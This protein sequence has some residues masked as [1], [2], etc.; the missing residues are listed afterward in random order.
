MGLN[1]DLATKLMFNIGLQ[2]LL[3]IQYLKSYDELRLFL[4]GKVDMTE[5]SATQGF[6]DLKVIYGPIFRLKFLPSLVYFMFLLLKLLLDFFVHLN[7]LLG[8]L[9]LLH[10]LLLIAVTLVILL[11]MR[12]I[13]ERL[14][15]L[16]RPF[17][18]H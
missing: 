5:L 10:H 2:K 7:L 3:F 8:K 12:L 9:L 15:L 18:L 4:S 17:P 1:F 13:S 14:L 11:R 16:R 6:P